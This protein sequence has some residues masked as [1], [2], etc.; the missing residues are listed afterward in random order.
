MK[1]PRLPRARVKVPGKLTD[2]TTS[3]TI[4]T[5]VVQALDGRSATRRVFLKLQKLGLLEGSTSFR[6]GLYPGEHYTL[7]YKLYRKDTFNCRRTFR[8]GPGKDS[9]SESAGTMRRLVG[10]CGYLGFSADGELIVIDQRY[11]NPEVL[12]RMKDTKRWTR[13]NHR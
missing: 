5:A 6:M 2:I 1:R 3:P 4:R 12:Y 11:P 8:F 9:R 13:R 10:Y 7:F